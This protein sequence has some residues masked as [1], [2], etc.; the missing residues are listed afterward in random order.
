[1]PH[2]FG[3]RRR[4]GLG[5]QPTTTGGWVITAGYVLV[6]VLAFVLLRRQGFWVFLVLT[7]GY[8]TVVVLTGRVAGEP[9]D[10]ADETEDEPRG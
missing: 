8:G 9:S 1:M 2:W 6:S 5:L 3:P 4:L 10:A 7:L